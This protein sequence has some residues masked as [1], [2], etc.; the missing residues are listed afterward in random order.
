MP[1]TRSALIIANGEYEDP[2][3]AALPSVVGD[4]GGLVGVLSD[5]AIGDFAV[6][7]LADQPS[8]LIAEAVEE[9]FADRAADDFL[10]LYISCHGLKS[11][12]GEL[13]FAAANTRMNRLNSTGVPAE[14]VNR[15][16]QASRSRR[17]VLVLD[18][19][20]SGAFES[21]TT[22]AARVAAAP[23]L[24]IRPGVTGTDSGWS[25]AGQV[26]QGMFEQLSGRGRVV[27]TASSATQYAFEGSVP[28]GTS[29]A[30][31][32]VFTAALVRGLLTGEADLD[33]DGL[34]SVN[35]LYAYVYRRLQES[36]TVQSPRISSHDLQGDLYIARS[37]LGRAGDPPAPP[38]AQ[39][40]AGPASEILA[41]GLGPVLALAYSPDGAML[42]VGGENGVRVLDA[43][44]RASLAGF[45]GAR[46]VR[47]LAFRPDGTVVVAGG[48]NGL[49]MW[50]TDTGG[51]R[52]YDSGVGVVRALAFHPGGN[53]LLVGG[54]QGLF[55]WV[56]P[57]SPEVVLST[58][59]E[60]TAVAWAPAGNLIVIAEENGLIQPFEPSS[61]ELLWTR[62]AHSGGAT[63]LAYSR[64][65]VFASAGLD[66]TVLIWDPMRPEPLRSLTGH[67]SRVSAIAFDP[68]G[69]TLASAGFDGTV[70]LW[71]P[72]TGEQLRVL[73]GHSGR[74]RAVAYSPDGARLVSAGDD[75]TVR[76]WPLDA[77]QPVTAA[78][79][80]PRRE[81]PG[82][83]S[84]VASAQD[85]LNNA[86]DVEMLAT[87]A[88]ATGTRPPLAIALLGK[89]GAGKSSLM[90]QMHRQIEQL[91][92]LSTNNPGASAFAATVR[93]IHFNAWHYSD[94]HLWTGLVDHLFRSLAED[95]GASADDAGTARAATERER[96]AAELAE[97][98]T[99]QRRLDARLADGDGPPV[100][101]GALASGPR[102]LLAAAGTALRDGWR[103]KGT[104]VA[105]A[106]ILAGGYAG[107]H[108]LGPWLTGA[109][110][111]VA[112][113]VAPVWAGLRAGHARGTGITGQARGRLE[114]RQRSV[115][116]R[117]TA[118]R[119]RLVEVD[120]AVRLAAFLGEHGDPGTYQEFRGLLGRV[121]HDLVRLDTMLRQAHAEW[122]AGRTAVPPPLERIVLY[123]DDLDRCP[124]RRVVELLAAVHL[125]L[126]LPLFV[127]VVAV[128]PR[129]LLKSLEHHYQELFDGPSPEPGPTDTDEGTTPLDYLDKI[130]QIPF[131]VPQATAEKTAG[132]LTA[133][134]GDPAPPP[135]AP[136][137][138][139]APA[140]PGRTE[141]ERTDPAV[142]GAEREPVPRPTAPVPPPVVRTATHGTPWEVPDLQPDQLRL[143]AAEITFMSRL[144]GLTPTPRAAKKL[145]NL[146]RLVR[147]GVDRDDLPEFVGTEPVRSGEPG[148]PGTHQVVQLLLAV[149][150]GSPDHSS[151][152]FRAILRADPAADIVTVLRTED[153]GPAGPRLADLIEATAA[154][155]PVITDTRP[156]QD[157]CPRL[158]RFSFHTRSL[159]RT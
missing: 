47:A 86:A 115:R 83:H 153:A 84:D 159:V 75:G 60:V 125:M 71:D 79:R 65:A 126:A 52:A 68:N 146:Y 136:A 28:A 64:H 59:G 12:D 35:E 144:G 74:V 151:R 27:I 89:W 81:L 30:P 50:H 145:V 56:A 34:I 21:G 5:P 46:V 29:E 132:Y 32:S 149:L 138:V 66:G 18:C 127:V 113:L 9:F 90:A 158:A 23:P 142:P 15:C 118:A 39:E 54:E 11:P 1:G 96:L 58:P 37:V 120:A 152:M 108:W 53:P 117:A 44:T 67:T 128:D 101:P 109:L 73:T 104:V 85:L 57:S 10:L 135:G 51:Q 112:A 122:A 92:Q 155:T 156:Y 140:A 69:T 134:L 93:Q 143:Q 100:W 33:G 110:G 141:R 105:W 26:A 154:V 72:G 8:Q 130:F 14:F 123:I 80:R 70:R 94:E 87:L 91:A 133:L 124:P 61:L 43:A 95:D 78:P 106:A 13:H 48:D 16:M 2:A 36:G 49:R 42:A 19:S 22:F 7:T 82:L 41:D 40:D 4:V 116:T 103:H 31:T 63:A 119:A 25:A 97:L 98:E 129:W 17:I 55:S 77:R 147:I 45:E 114:E 6:R 76:A 99:E 62:A 150:V 3:L 148:A 111:G 131:S 20:Y 88:A 137:A 107:W 38:D 102:L 139:P 24:G 157:W 121:H